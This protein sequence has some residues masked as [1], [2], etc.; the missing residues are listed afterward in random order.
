MNNPIKKKVITF[1]RL[2]EVE[3]SKDAGSAA[4][5][6]VLDMLYGGFVGDS[7][8]LKYSMTSQTDRQKMQEE[9]T[10]HI[11][12]SALSHENIDLLNQRDSLRRNVRRGTIL[13]KNPESAA[14]FIDRK[15]PSSEDVMLAHEEQRLLKNA[16]KA[17]FEQIGGDVN[18]KRILVAC[19]AKGISFHSTHKLAKACELGIRDVEKAKS[20]L[21]YLR[22]KISAENLD[23][24]LNLI[25]K[26]AK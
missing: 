12:N 24:F 5:T 17:I 18:V 1:Q 14:P 2:E 13:K 21:R 6:T 23:E 20:R 25:K 16:L 7:N 11:K 3:G 22:E 4:P 26:E 19:I 9:A 15:I 10:R 8:K